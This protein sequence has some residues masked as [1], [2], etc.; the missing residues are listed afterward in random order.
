[1]AGT[2]PSKNSPQVI[3]F[4]AGADSSREASTIKKIMKNNALNKLTHCFKKMDEWK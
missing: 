3:K 2:T 4:M 1:M